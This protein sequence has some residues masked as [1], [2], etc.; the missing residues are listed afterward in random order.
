MNHLEKIKEI[1]ADLLDI[2]ESEINPE[3]Y[4]IRELDVESIDLLEIAVTLNSEF[5]VEIDDDAIF[6]KS[7]R[8][9]LT[10]AGDA[11]L[12]FLIEKYPFLTEERLEE[13]VGDV[14]DGPVL[15]VKDLVS[16]VQWRAGA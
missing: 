13:I 12:P 9:H 14:G 7:L 2:D 8:I 5:G 4:L 3:T 6:L 11:P 1:L 15:R 10:D 16:Y